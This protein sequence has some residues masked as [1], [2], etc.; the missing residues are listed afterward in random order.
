MCKTAS[1]SYVVMPDKA[2]PAGTLFGGELMKWMDVVT[3]MAAVRFCQ[4][5][6][7]TA[8]VENISFLRPFPIGSFVNL[9]AEVISVGR[10]SMRVKVDVTVEKAGSAPEEA[11]HAVFVCVAIDESGRPKPV[12]RKL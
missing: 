11:A 3:G 8:A 12:G 1:M 6:I 10:S 9:N 4:C 2:N 5:L 7:T